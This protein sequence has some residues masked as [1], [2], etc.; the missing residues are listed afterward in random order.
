MNGLFDR[1]GPRWFTIPAH[2][3]FLADLAAG[4]IAGLSADE[5]ATAVVLT[6]TRRSARAL[7]AAFA[8]VSL[9]RGG[10]GGLLLPQ[11]RP[12]G[13]LEEGEPPFE[14]GELSLD[15]PAA[16]SPWRRRF[17]LAA[18]A[19]EL[20]PGLASGQALEMADA[21]GNLIDSLQIEEIEP[22]DRIATLVEGELARHWMRSAELLTKVLDRWPAHLRDLGLMDVNER[23]VRLLRA[24]RDQWAASP[25]PHALIAAGS[26][27]TA[28]PAADLLATVAASPRGLVVLPG[29]DENLADDAWRKVQ[30]DEQHPQG[31]LARLLLRAH[32]TRAQVATWPA[33]LDGRARWRRRL[34]NEALRPAEATDDWLK[35]IAQLKTEGAAIGAD[36]FAEGLEGLSILTAR[37][38]DEAA[39]C[40]AL[41]LRE[42]LETPGKTAALITPDQALARRVRLR[43]ARF[44]V[45]TEA[46]SG[47]PLAGFP[48][49]V[50][51][52]LMAGLVAE[53]D[54]PAALLA[55]LK[56][57]LTRLGRPPED[58]AQAAAGLEREGLRGPRRKH[59]GVLARLEAARRK[60]W[61]EDAPIVLAEALFDALAIAAAPFASGEAAPA[62]A[63]RALTA[64]LEA[65]GDDRLWSGPAGECAA[66]LLSALI[67]EGEGL[68]PTDARGFLDLLQRLLASESVRLPGQGH[69]R[70]QILGALEARLVRADRLVLAG[71]EEGVWPRIPPADPFLSRPMR[72]RLG[73]PEPERRVGL[74]AHDFAQAACAGEVMLV[75]SQRREGAPAVESRWLWRLRTLV[76][77]GG[78]TLPH[79]TDLVDLAR[80]LDAPGAFAPA[81]RPAPRPPVADRPR[82]LFVTR[83][84]ALTR[85]P[86]AVWA[87]D[88]LGLRRL[89]RPDEPVDVRARGTAIHSAFE[90][91]TKLHPGALP[92]GAAAQFERFYLE[93]LETQGMPAPELTRERAL[94]REAAAWIVDYEARRR[95][96]GRAIIVEATGEHQLH[97][98][99]GAFTL[100]AKA[101]RIEVGPDG[102][103][104]VLDYKTG[105]A[106]SKKL[107]Q[108][109]F[110]PQLTLTM[111]IAAAGG[112]PCV[113][114]AE[115]GELVY[116]EITGRRP[117]GKEEVRGDTPDSAEMAAKALAGL[118]AMIERYEDP[119]QAY[120]SR[121]APQFVHD[122]AGDYGHLA[123][124]FE[125]SSGG[126][127]DDE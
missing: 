26:T 41:A 10:P 92:D 61:I 27:G 39:L 22:A 100:K 34:V 36:P 23:R 51:A 24:L 18:L 42:A 60:G 53:P 28:P 123:R 64:A 124:V 97:T 3:P 67:H 20:Q 52:A 120:L 55:V 25:P 58:L 127:G 54:D 11:I 106:P 5:L 47:Q 59:E 81:P 77:G 95:S 98:R 13:D 7:A 88:I 102:R 107:V 19:A 99:G 33:S 12:I 89:D 9:E 35:Q 63:A 78:A 87:R 115:A 21:L 73:L 114:G 116:L 72:K 104:H 50:L 29:L 105:K 112:F 57:P 79:R 31:A 2:R 66:N 93:A 70:L 15:L 62:A 74:S 91:L 108:T 48:A 94:A 68:P 37:D 90:Q 49:A 117:A 110:S 8:D 6:P 80:A 113:T 65:L 46:S 83:V 76:E 101:D 14:P 32:V 16:I 118:T 56:H 45:E 40:C 4:L 44:G 38:E 126:E 75:H 111:A 85:D 82:A 84:E 43:L 122:Y 71:L 86:Y 30:G 69:P 17:E 103:I 96:D 1:E 109:S 125:W 121:A 119:D